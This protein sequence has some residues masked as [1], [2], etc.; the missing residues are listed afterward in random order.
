MYSSSHYPSRKRSGRRG[1]TNNE[2]TLM[3]AIS[4]QTLPGTDDSTVIP[5]LVSTHTHTHTHTQST[6][7][8]THT[9]TQSPETYMW[10]TGHMSSKPL[11]F[12]PQPD[13]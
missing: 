6:H 4:T 7:I 8:H 12:Y 3:E 2:K 13:S 10:K 11:H 5:V 9:H 1:G